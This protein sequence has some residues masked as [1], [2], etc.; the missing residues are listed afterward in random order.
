MEAPVVAGIGLSEHQARAGLAEHGPNEIQPAAPRS[1]ARRFVARLAN[2]LLLV[3]LA[4]SA[5][6]A[7]TGD[8]LSFGIVLAVILAS[9]VLDLVQEQRADRAIE[10]LQQAVA[11]RVRVWRDGQCVERPAPELVPGDLVQLG[12]GSL[13]P[14][15][16]TVLQATDFFVNQALL[17]GEAV[18]V[19]KHAAPGAPA[20]S[21]APAEATLQEARAL[22]MGS[23]VVSGSALMRVD[24]TGARTEFGRMAQSLRQPEPPTE[25]ERG[26]R[27]F[28]MMLTRATVALV[29]AVLLLNVL[30]QRPPLES[31]L[32]AVA[33][34]V[35]LTPEL[36][37]M[38]VSVTLARGAMRLA[39]SRV[40]VRR[41]SAVQDL[42]AMDVLCTD[43]TGTLT[44]A[45]LRVERAVDA[46]GL[47]CEAVFE[48]AWLNSH[49]ESGVKSALDDAI[50]ARRTPGAVPW[51][52][53]DEVP[54]DFERRRVSV[55]LQ[56]GDERL[57]ICK[58]A[59]EDVLRL[60]AAWDDGQAEPAL[61][62]AARARIAALFE[63]HSAQGL[64]LLAVARRRV[65][66]GTVDV[67]AADEHDFVFA[68]FVAFADPPKAST[69]A[70][71][72]ELHAHGIALKIITGDNELVTR[73]LCQALGLRVQG[74]LTGERIAQL[75]DHGLRA[76]VTRH[77]LFCRVT[78]EQ[79]NRIVLAL[80]ARGHVVGYL[81]DG[82]NDAAPLHSAD[83]GIS[84]DGAV[85]VARQAADLV[86]LEHDLGVLQQGVREGRRTVLNVDKYLFMATSSNFG[87]MVSMAAA[88][89][90]L[91]FLPM[92]PA[93]IL[94]NNLLYDLSELALPLDRV[95][96]SE[97]LKPRRWDIAR[98][99]RFMLW[100]GPLSSVF[101]LAAFALLLGVLRATEPVFQSAWFVQSLATQVLVVF[102]IR[103]PGTAWRDRPSPWV[104]AASLGVAALALALPYLPPGRAFGFVPLPAS[105]L[106]MVGTL[107]AAYLVAAEALKRLFH[108]SAPRRRRRRAPG[109]R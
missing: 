95:R 33:L 72:R 86:L 69:A 84:V 16:G 93:Q 35:G 11:L 48:L 7:L 45:T 9:V 13:V 90:W 55:L 25:F 15:D 50:L 102:V 10:S 4:A 89:L 49:F 83:V 109:P 37:P 42:G 36:L 107:T 62:A 59:P 98:I 27:R 75:D 105:A 63:A 24:A 88:A 14:A 18:P 108:R 54:F 68:G 17:T 52:K 80:R 101:D 74:V 78:P 71:L 96:E 26:T 100:F 32:F 31:F 30:Y 43:K 66:A 60:S 20:G 5:I 104:A 44:E 57:L 67:S 23:S 99:R 92:R 73:H 51:R 65:D 29:L 12:A 8:A 82:A 58:G 3:L 41:L 106:V 70:A 56:R 81:G 6:A 40:V 19:E 39:R 76:A 38:I 28:G 21:A 47:D 1:L 85:D 94:L 22:F 77:N 97:M 53:L 87:N 91:P 2:P 79:K 64:R 46:Q 61:D 34:A 103:T